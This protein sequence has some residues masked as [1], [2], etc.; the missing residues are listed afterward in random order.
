MS[1]LGKETLK[2]KRNTKKNIYGMPGTH[3]DHFSVISD[4]DFDASGLFKKKG[5]I[6]KL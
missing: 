5:N 1:T 3:S 4:G 6:S 2:L